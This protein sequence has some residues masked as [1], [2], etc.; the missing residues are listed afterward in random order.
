VECSLESEIGKALIGAR[1]KAIQKVTLPPSPDIPF[2]GP[3]FTNPTYDTLKYPSRSRIY[4]RNWGSARPRS[5][6]TDGGSDVFATR[7]GE[8]LGEGN[9]ELLHRAR[10]G[11][12]RS[13]QRTTR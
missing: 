3:V 4:P 13:S 9:A 8:T 7:D 10:R 6:P 12:P 1:S 5:R 2:N 11:V